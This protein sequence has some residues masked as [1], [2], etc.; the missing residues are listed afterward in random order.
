[1]STAVKRQRNL[2]YGKVH[3]A[4][5]A[6]LRPLSER[7]PSTCNDQNGN[8]YLAPLP[9]RP[10]S[11]GR[12]TGY[13]RPSQETRHPSPVD[14][15]HSGTLPPS[16]RYVAPEC[17][18]SSSCDNMAAPSS[19]PHHLPSQ[20]SMYSGRQAMSSAPAF[21]ISTYEDLELDDD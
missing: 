10:L 3:P 17:I 7:A 14:A 21:S 9:P 8:G 15:P 5:V 19:L 4:P 12:L 11:T 1:M 20:A 18:A 6:A 2:D 16:R 13:K